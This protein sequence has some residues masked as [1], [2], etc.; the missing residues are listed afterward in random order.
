[1]I[2]SSRRA[3][4]GVKSA[5]HRRSE[6][7][8]DARDLQSDVATE[9]GIERQID[10]AERAATELPTNHEPSDRLRRRLIDDIEFEPQ[11]RESRP[12]SRTRRRFLAR[13]RLPEQTHAVEFFLKALFAVAASSITAS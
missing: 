12:R 6:Q 2:Q 7:H 4:F 8:I 5:K 1:M 3:S 11:R 9:I 13:K 10:D